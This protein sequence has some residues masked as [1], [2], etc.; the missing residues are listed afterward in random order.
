MEFQVA[1]LFE[2]VVDNIP[3]RES[4]VLGK[5]RLAFADL[6]KRANKAAHMLKKIGVRRF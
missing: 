5:Q 3:S 4:I 2:A 6:D 1:D